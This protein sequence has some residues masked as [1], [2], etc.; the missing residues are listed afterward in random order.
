LTPEQNNYLNRVRGTGFPGDDDQLLIAGDEA[1]HLLYSGQPAA[2]VI[3]AT[4]GQYGASPE[5]AT[6]VV[7][8]A[9]ATMCVRAPG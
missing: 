8:A 3:D 9:R 4:A 7:H 5:Q 6:A 1:C 2:A